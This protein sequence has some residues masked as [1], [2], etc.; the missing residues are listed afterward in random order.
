[1]TI[2]FFLEKHY[3]LKQSIQSPGINYAT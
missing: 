2:V 1:M 3:F